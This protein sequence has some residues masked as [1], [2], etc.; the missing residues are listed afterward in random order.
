[1]YIIKVLR[2]RITW[3]A[4]DLWKLAR[5]CKHVC[6]LCLS[7]TWNLP[8]T[9]LPSSQ[10]LWNAMRKT[11]LNTCSFV[12]NKDPYTSEITVN[13]DTNS[14]VGPANIFPIFDTAMD[15]AVIKPFEWGSI[16]TKIHIDSVT[17]EMYGD[18]SY[19]CFYWQRKMC[20]YV[21]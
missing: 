5:S 8:G 3:Y 1:M 20:Q 9:A 15:I 16:P 13:F 12:W 7:V 2:I 21:L 14:N 10:E 19:C 18:I 11:V 4:R 17:L 6:L